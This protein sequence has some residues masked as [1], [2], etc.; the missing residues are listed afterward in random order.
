MK[1]AVTI[2]ATGAQPRK[3]V[4]EATGTLNAARAVLMSP[5]TEALFE[6]AR[7]GGGAGMPILSAFPASVADKQAHVDDVAK[8]GGE[9]LLRLS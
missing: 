3:T 2:T 4:L 6:E 8:N 5:E 9:A 7:K 1:V